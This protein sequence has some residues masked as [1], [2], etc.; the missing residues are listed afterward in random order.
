MKI[1]HAATAASDTSAPAFSFQE[2]FRFDAN[3]NVIQQRSE[4]RDD[5]ATMSPTPVRW[6]TKDMTYDT[7]D[8]K[9]SETISTDDVPAISLT[10]SYAY[11][12]NGNPRKTIF[13]AGIPILR[14]YHERVLLDS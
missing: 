5:G 14:F 7:L 1:V 12:S 4:R 10:T 3:N 9:T 2:E 8:R 13:P 11:D 6:I